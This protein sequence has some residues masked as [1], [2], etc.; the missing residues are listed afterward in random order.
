[1]DTK[2]AGK[3]GVTTL[4]GLVLFA[5]VYWYLSHGLFDW[6]HFR[7]RVVFTDTN[8]LMVQTPVRMNGVAIGEVERIELSQDPA[9]RLRP[10][11]TLAIRN[12]FRG[13]IPADSRIGISS[14]ILITNPQIEIVPG[15]STASLQPGDTWPQQYVEPPAGALAQLSPEAAQAVKQLTATLQQM[16]PNLNRTIAQVQGILKRTDAVMA[17]LQAATG[18]AKEIIADPAIRRTL[19]AS[20]NNLKATTDT[21]RAAAASI[22]RDLKLMVHRN[23]GKFDELAN[24]AVDLLQRLGDTVDAARSALTRLTEQVTDPRLQQSLLDTLDLARATV[25]RFNQIASD[26]HQITGDPSI[27]SNI[28]TTMEQL[29]ET[30]EEARPLVERLNN[31]VGSI[32]IPKGPPNFGI[33]RPEFNIDFLE[34]GNAPHFRS[35]VSMRLPIGSHNAF[36]LGIYDFA[37]RNKLN[38]QYETDLGRTASLRYGIYASKLGVGLGWHATRSASLVLDLY[39]PNNLQFDARALVGLNDDFSLWLGAD[40]LFKHTVPLIG[41]RLRR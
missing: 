20:L 15:T 3:V 16:G 9:T 33:G 31:L 19:H 12:E 8:G 21:A 40:N 18:S 34:R 38:A 41:L 22:S 10:V 1:M 5:G 23:S 32:H 36:N 25:A 13:R 7:L 17:N 11:V 26:I 6:T 24:G 30:S 39:E 37:E 2:A 35:D 4:V 14:G 27:Q 28:K 29:K